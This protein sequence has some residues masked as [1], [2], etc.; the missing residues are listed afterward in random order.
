MPDEPKPAAPGAD[1]PFV[2]RDG[3]EDHD[4]PRPPLWQIVLGCFLLLAA[5]L[6]VAAL[7]TYGALWDFQGWRNGPGDPTRQR[8]R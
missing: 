1:E 5:A 2:P 7:F 4:K 3:S 6:W 8:G